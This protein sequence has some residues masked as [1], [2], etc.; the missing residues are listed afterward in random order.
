[1]I[2]RREAEAN[3]GISAGREEASLEQGR[4]QERD[5]VYYA[6]TNSDRLLHSRR[7]QHGGGTLKAIVWTVLLVYGAFAAYRILPAYVAQYQLMDKMQEQARFAVVNRYTDDQIRDDIFKVVQDLEI[8]VKRDQ[9]KVTNTSKVVSIS[10]EYTVPVDLLVY[11][12]DL[13]F[14]PSSENKSII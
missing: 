6:K 11:H 7:A 9:I 13:H 8:P 12:L 4:R 5:L 10:M 2:L 1:L 14:T 3:A